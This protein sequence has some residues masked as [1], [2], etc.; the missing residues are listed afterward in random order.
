M[1][2]DGQHRGSVRF[3]PPWQPPRQPV[4]LAEGIEGG[5]KQIRQRKGPPSSDGPL[6]EGWRLVGGRN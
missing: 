2:D 5:K 6:S 3:F 1:M 4:T